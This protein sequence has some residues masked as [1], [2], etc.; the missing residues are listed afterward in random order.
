MRRSSSSARH[1][2]LPAMG[3]P[4]QGAVPG[5]RPALAS[6]RVRKRGVHMMLAIAL[7]LTLLFLFRRSSESPHLAP[8]RNDKPAHGIE[9]QLRDWDIKDRIGES[10][11]PRKLS[12]TSN[13]PID[14]LST[15]AKND[16]NN[17]LG[18][19]SK[20]LDEAV[21]EYN[22][23]YNLPP[24][25]H[26]DKWFQFAKS[27]NVQ[28]IDEFDTIFDLIT[29]FWGLKPATI[30]SRAREALGFPNGLL[31]LGIRNHQVAFTQSVGGYEWQ[32]EATIKMM[33]PFVK[34]LPDMDL[35]FNIHDESRIVIPYDDLTRLVQKAR[36]TNMPAANSN[37]QL[38]NHFTPKIAD[39]SSRLRFED[40]KFTRFREAAHQPTWSTSRMSC[41]PD[42]PAR[43]LD[44]D[45]LGDKIS[46]YSVT[47]GEFVYNASALMD[48]CLS[49]SL[50]KSFGFFDRPN[51][52]KV[53]HDLFPI[54]SQSKISSY[55]D[56][57]YPSPW[58]WADRVVY[59]ETRDLTWGKKHNALYWRGSTTGGFSRNGGWRRQHR[60][61]LVQKLNDHKQVTVFTD[62]GDDAHPQW[63]ATKA[64]RGQYNNLVDVHFSH[65]GQCDP[66]DCEAQKQ[67]FKVGE[68]VD[69]QD[70]WSYK[71]LLDM[72]GNAFSGRFYAFLQSRSQ[73]FKQALFQEWHKEWLMP[74]IHFVPMS[75]RGE[76]WLELVRFFSNSEAKAENMAKASA[77]WANK[78]LR[79][80][81]MEAWFFRLLLEYSRVIDDNRESIGYDPDA[82]SAASPVGGN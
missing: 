80:E 52:Y 34:Y 58:Y 19:Q 7:I 8:V 77:T 78:V 74:W 66:G 29:P 47:E 24:P 21:K 72:D 54:F 55:S 22:R 2:I 65:V 76:D 41:A 56:I 73:V 12:D 59:N 37:K 30:R 63:S 64:A 18:R 36:E 67:F 70:A 13:H 46:E 81:D 11:G 26:F 69:M 39:V 75:M 5:F 44:D 43:A 61:Y 62:T 4:R 17:M 40:A 10:S 16:F 53:A 31:G 1:G 9:D 45:D 51:G 23:R 68:M 71:H 57:I 25:P 79:K 32:E 82:K 3:Q 28:L 42:S 50:S 38:A 48:I 27:H 35:A 60:Q 6:F 33:A 15:N 20:T 14:Y 49:P